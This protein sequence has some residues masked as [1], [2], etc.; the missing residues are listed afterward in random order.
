MPVFCLSGELV[1]SEL[2]LDD[3]AV[4][5]AANATPTLTLTLEKARAATTLDAD[6]IV[7]AH[8]IGGEPF[9]TV[10]RDVA[11]H[12]IRVHGYADFVV[13]RD[14]R[15]VR[16]VPAPDCPDDIIA[17]LFV[18][19]V[20]PNAL[21]GGRTPVFHSSM[22]A[23][24]G[25]GIMFLGDPGLGKST[26]ACGLTPPA[27]WLCDDAAVLRLRGDAVEVHPSYPFARLFGDSLR[28]MGVK[29]AERVSARHDKWRVQRRV[30]RGPC[31]VAAI[32]SLS[33]DSALRLVRQRPR[34]V[35]AELARHLF[36]IDP[37]DRT[38]L[39]GELAMLESIAARVPL[40]ALH[41]PRRY[42][43]LADV[44]EALSAV[45]SST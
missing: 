29:T 43:A 19:R 37:S 32:F 1:L 22:V 7:N 45:L 39:M 41:Y 38:A 24:D 16:C 36:R 2:P 3:Y 28:A 9:L 10:A 34:D 42:D 27:E 18:D 30:A 11:G 4:R 14:E 20:L 13:D 35:V 26:L 33:S 40:Y 23:L 21:S 25:R 5:A 17:Q 44:R 12:R 15:Q 8:E 31:R 6:R